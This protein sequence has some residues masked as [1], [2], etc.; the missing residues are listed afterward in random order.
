LVDR[1]TPVR[2]SWLMSRVR[3]KNTTPELTV[4]KAAHSLGLRFRLHRRDLPGTPDLVFPKWKTV[5]FVHGC[6]WHRHVGCAKASVPKTRVC[7]WTEKFRHNVKR[8]RRNQKLLRDT[9]WSVLTVW[10]CEAKNPKHLAAKI[11]ETFGLG[12]R[13][14]RKAKKLLTSRR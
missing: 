10:E 3:G 2:R 7:Y 9:G 8:D 11:A 5:I 6:F 4:R 1:L 14:R 12:R 13:S